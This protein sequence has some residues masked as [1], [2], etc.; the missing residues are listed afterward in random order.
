MRIGMLDITDLDFDE[1][2]LKCELPV[3]ACFVTKWCHSC[4]P[5]CLI[6]DQF[7]EEYDGDVKF[8]KVDMDT[9]PELTA[10]Y[11][12]R[13]VPT[14]ITF[15]NA[16]PVDRALGIQDRDSIRVIMDRLATASVA[17]GMQNTS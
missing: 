9:H 12:L 6:A 14:I 11:Q 4:F 16:Q 15:L 13:V 3:F 10:K 17:A 2:V 5:T 8:V 1:E 7:A